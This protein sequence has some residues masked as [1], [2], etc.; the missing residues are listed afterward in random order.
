LSVSRSELEQSKK[1]N[2]VNPMHILRNHLTQQAIELAQKEDY[3]E[4]QRL[5]K[6]LQKPFD[7][8]S[9]YETYAELPP[10]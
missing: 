7:E 9:E 5:Y 8:R 1:M 10:H 3:S 2:A 4:V 6:I